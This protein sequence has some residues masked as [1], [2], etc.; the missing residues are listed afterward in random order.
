MHKASLSVILITKNEEENLEK[1]LE[2]VKWADEL[3]VYDSGST[4][5]TL[6]IAKKFTEKVFVD[7]DWQGFGRQ[8]QKA[9]DKA[10]CQWVLMVDADERLSPDLQNEICEVLKKNNRSSVYAIPRLSW[11][12]GRF[13]RHSGWYPDYVLRFYPR[14]RARYNSA[15]VHE[16]LEFGPEMQVVYL[17]ESLCHYTFRD[18]EHWTIKTAAYAKAWADQRE[19][20]GEE[21]GLMG[22]PTHAIG[23]FFKTYLLRRGF[24][25][26]PQGFLLAV[27]GAHSKFLKYADLWSRR[28]V[29]ESHSE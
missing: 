17:S 9:Q 10:T 19:S 18:L 11:F 5:G 21:C 26:G 13:I 28:R 14:D 7:T 6:E 29:K 3:V 25:D 2:S 16:N 1:C 24:L 12:L 27:L 15:L 20:R 8:R 22:G 23:Y 4:D